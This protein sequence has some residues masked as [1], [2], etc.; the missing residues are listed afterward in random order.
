MARRS[1]HTRDELKELAIAAGCAL[2]V[3]KGFAQF[4]ARGVAGRIGYTVGTLYNVFG[5]LDEFILCLNARTLD[6]WYDYLCAAID[7]A[8]SGQLLK[9]AMAYI[10]FAQQHVNLW[11]A[12]F[13]HQ[14]EQEVPDWYK[15][16]TRRFFDLVESVLAGQSNE[17]EKTIRIQAKTLWAGIHGIC[18]LSLGNQLAQVD[19]GSAETLARHLIEALVV[20]KD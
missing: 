5:S 13:L 17:D 19:A 20:E 2:I 7:G 18:V 10:N 14:S 9:L 15:A 12:L 4:S 16:K 11:S 6:A 1:D 3:E 8:K